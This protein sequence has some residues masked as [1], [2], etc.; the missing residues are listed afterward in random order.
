MTL[1]LANRCGVGTGGGKGGLKL[2]IRDP[3][4]SMLAVSSVPGNQNHFPLALG[5]FPR[6]NGLTQMVLTQ[7]PPKMVSFPACRSESLSTRLY[8]TFAR[9]S[10]SLGSGAVAR[11]GIIA[12]RPC[13]TMYASSFET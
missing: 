5:Y 1:E 3:S 10:E 12:A 4:A 2:E 6:S 9:V 11:R 7:S 8:R 13:T